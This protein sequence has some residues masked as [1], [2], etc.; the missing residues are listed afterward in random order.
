[1]HGPQFT[2][3]HVYLADHGKILATRERGK[4]A[5]GHLREIAE[6]PGDL[7]LDFRAVEAATPPFL[8]EII[9]SVQSIINS[10]GRTGRLVVAA[11]MNDDVAET[12]GFVVARKK[13]PIPHRTGSTV[14]LLEG[15]PHLA[16]TLR[17]AQQLR[18][19]TA[20]QLAERLKIKD[21]AAT[22]RLK[23]LLKTGAVARERDA[24]ASRGVRD[25][26][27]AA[28]PELVEAAP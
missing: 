10:A 1:M 4:E 19:F 26:Y 16:E 12:L 18:S 24:S 17:E 27:R 20:P 22:Q 7:I 9:D 14:E 21:D 2:P 5:A 6:E 8:Q 15:T 25:L 23:S 13:F 28:V 3:L 11:H